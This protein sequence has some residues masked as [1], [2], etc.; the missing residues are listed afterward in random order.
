MSKPKKISSLIPKI[1]KSF[2]KKSNLVELQANWEKVVG[3]KISS[4]CYA[5]SLKKINK[6]NILIIKSTEPDLLELSY[7]SEKLKNKINEFYSK[8]FINIIKFKKSL[9]K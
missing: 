4:K 1:F 5:Y 2:K 7:S 3:K 8:E 9:Q 6:K